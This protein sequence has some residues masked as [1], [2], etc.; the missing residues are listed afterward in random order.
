M[1][2]GNK[3]CNIIEKLLSNGCVCA[4]MLARDA[5][6]KSVMQHKDHVHHWCGIKQQQKLPLHQCFKIPKSTT[7]VGCIYT[8]LQ[9]YAD[10]KFFFVVLTCARS[11]RTVLKN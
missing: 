3:I 6:N 10:Y 5:P 11:S 4:A 8:H 7:L 2:A 1:L 9:S